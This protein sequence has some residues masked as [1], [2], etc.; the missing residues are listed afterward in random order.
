MSAVCRPFVLYPFL[1]VSV[2]DLFRAG[3]IYLLP[4]LKLLFF[5][6]SPLLPPETINKAAAHVISS[7]LT[8]MMVQV[9]TGLRYQ[10]M[11]RSGWQK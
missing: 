5:F 7:F 11:K 2:L 9:K 1:S 8:G 3:C 6:L 4:D 10:V